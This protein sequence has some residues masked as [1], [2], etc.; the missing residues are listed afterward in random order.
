M[1]GVVLSVLGVGFR[2]AGNFVKDEAH[3]AFVVVGVIILALG[4][5]FILASLMAYRPVV[6][7]RPVPAATRSGIAVHQCV[8]SR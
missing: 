6:A 5:G 8:T 7:A 1:A 3:E 4:I 2:Y